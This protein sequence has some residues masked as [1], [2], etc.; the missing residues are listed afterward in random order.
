M[1]H[2]DKTAAQNRIAGIQSSM[3]RAS[4]RLD[5]GDRAGALNALASARRQIEQLQ[6]I[7][8]NSMEASQ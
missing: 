4:E 5:H 3:R 1:N 8:K 2:D 7:L 6:E